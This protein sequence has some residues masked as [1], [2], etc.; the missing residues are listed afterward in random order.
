MK[1][2]RKK[3]FIIIEVEL[4]DCP[5][6]QDIEMCADAIMSGMSVMSKHIEAVPELATNLPAGIIEEIKDSSNDLF[7]RWEISKKEKS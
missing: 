5:P 2:Y 7:E 4:K 1:F 3:N 6:G